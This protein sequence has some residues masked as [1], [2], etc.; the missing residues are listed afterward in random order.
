MNRLISHAS[1]LFLGGLCLSVAVVV[2]GCLSSPSP[3]K[4]SDQT[5]TTASILPSLVVD[6]SVR[7]ASDRAAVRESDYESSGA[8]QPIVTGPEASASPVEVGTLVV[9]VDE[10]PAISSYGETQGLGEKV[11]WAHDA[12][13]VKVQNSIARVDKR[14]AENEEVKERVPASRFRI[15]LFAEVVDEEDTEFGFDP[16][17]NMELKTPNIERRLSLFVT[18]EELGEVPGTD[19][20]DRDQGVRLGLRRDLFDWAKVDVGVKVDWPPD[21]FVQLKWARRWKSNNWKIYPGLKA[22]WELEDGFGSS[23]SLTGDR[24]FGRKL[25]RSGTGARWKEEEDGVQINHTLILG[26]AREL[27][28]ERKLG[29]RAKG[30]DLANGGGFR[31]RIKGNSESSRIESHEGLFFIKRPMRGRWAYFIFAPGVAFRNERSWK[32]E[33]ELRIGVDLLFWDVGDR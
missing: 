23:L 33:P 15:G 19:A 27:I 6:S 11:D 18:T 1:S 13:F 22:F 24:W 26:H 31:Y 16:E 21:P 8:S 17:F 32:A 25:I 30:R 7:P 3:I 20:S 12:L 2:T 4:A 14:F 5:S 10:L 28:D 29:G 9:Y